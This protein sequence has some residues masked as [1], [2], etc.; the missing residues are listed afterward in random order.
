MRYFIYGNSGG[1][2]QVKYELKHPAP[3][4]VFNT[5]NDMFNFFTN[6]IEPFSNGCSKGDL[7]VKYY[8]YDDRIKKHVY[9]IMTEQFYDN[10]VY[11]KTP[12]FLSYFVEI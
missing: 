7:Y 2:D 1:I 4:R 10:E 11:D 8:G 3:N 12:H 9:I 5:I 6:G